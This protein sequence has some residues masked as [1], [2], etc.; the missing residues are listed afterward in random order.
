[1]LSQTGQPAHHIST[2]YH[3]KMENPLI[4]PLHTA[5]VT[6]KQVGG[7]GANLAKLVQAGLPVPDGFMITTAGYYIYLQANNLKDRLNNRLSGLDPTDPHELQL[8]SAEIRGWFS[9]GVMPPVITEKL[10]EAYAQLKGGP[11]AVRSSATAEDLPELSFAGQQDTYLHVVDEAALQ[12]AVVDCWSSLWTARAIGYRAKNGIPHE[13]VALSVIVQEMVSAE[14]AGVMF[15]A[16]PLTGVRNETVIDATLGLGEA[17]VGGHVEPDHY[18]IDT[19]G[20]RILEKTLGSKAIVMRGKAGGGLA[21]ESVVDNGEAALP[22]HEI[23]ALFAIG[24]QVASLYDSP[25]DIEWARANDR[26]FVLQS[27]PITSLFPIP[28]EFG[29]DP[30]Q[31]FF[32]FGAVQGL[33]DPMTPLG[34]DAIRL[35]FAGG[36]ELFG[37]DLT[38]ETQ[39]VL[40]SAGERLWGNMT[41]VLRHPFGRRMLPRLFGGADPG[42]VPALESLLNEPR[43]GAG[44]GRLRLQTFRRLFVYA[45]P[46]VKRI[47]FN[48]RHPDNQAEKIQRQSRE[49]INKL[50]IKSESVSE[51]KTQLAHHIDLYREIRNGFIYVVPEIFTAAAAGLIPLFILNALA[52][53]LTGTRDIALEI[54]RGLPYNVTTE[55]DLVLWKTA[56]TI[57]ADPGAC[58]DFQSKSAAALTSEYLHGHLP[59]AA[60]KAIDGFLHQFGIRG[61]G[62]IDLG[63]PRW[64]EEP[65]PIIQVL[66]SYLKIEGE[67]AA[68]DAVFRRGAQAAEAA[69]GA[70]EAAARQTLGGRLKARL[71]RAL[72]KRVRA[73]AGLRESPKFH[74]I[75]MMGIIRQGLLESGSTLAKTGVVS[76][77][78][79][80]LFL[81]LNELE[82]LAQGEPRDW[83]ALIASRRANYDRE[84]RRR[85]VPRLVVSDGRVFYGGVSDPA[86]EAGVLIGS[87]VSP[88]VVEGLVRVVLD[89]QQ[90]N[91][92]PGE[93]LV[94]PGTD[95]AWTPLFLAAGGLVMEVGGMI[96]HGAIVA[97]EY[98][99]PAVVG[100]DQATTRLQ[101]GQRIRVDGSMGRIVMLDDKNS[102]NRN[103]ES[104]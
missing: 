58:E 76:Q 18:V 70:L 41:P 96:T 4:L 9:T 84:K 15:T 46:F 97:R 60:Q 55:M 34:Q 72:A 63:R 90:A 89:P 77:P 12:T 79:D 68:P 53:R 101:T 24:Q 61:V 22:D 62:E 7:K 93:I 87:P 8:A 80:L 11:V 86:G 6:L 16:N 57:K 98:G 65:A 83:A 3:I 23:L 52:I 50:R 38:H 39:G 28:E 49:E 54:T 64:R 66:Q 78:D 14:A 75:Q 32:S 73:L 56:R 99:I 36:G 48:M 30:L 88:G 2:H 44:T 94:C 104:D 71:I 67:T 20:A 51:E 13:E 29:P 85:Q 31:V 47:L 100:V 27:R 1:L 102:L 81:Y 92:S 35:I 91:L 5:D 21:T 43:L 69:I 45:F 74:I 37:F 19:D 59:H 103:S 33:L 42:T 25:Q 10:L 40:Y 26:F 95:P 82:A 17:L